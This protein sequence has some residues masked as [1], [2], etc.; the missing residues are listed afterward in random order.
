MLRTMRSIH[1]SV[2]NSLRTSPVLVEVEG[3]DLDR[4][5]LVD[6]ERVLALRLLVVLEAHVDLRPD[7]ARQQALVVA[8]VVRRDV[9]DTCGRS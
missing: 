2:V 1:S 5:E 9:D 6:P 3:G 4:R 8:H 7:A